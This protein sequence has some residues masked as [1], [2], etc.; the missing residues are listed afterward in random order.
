[1]KLVTAATRGMRYRP[2]VLCTMTCEVQLL[3][4]FNSLVGLEKQSVH[5]RA[6]YSGTLARCFAAVEHDLRIEIVRQGAKLQSRAAAKAA[7]TN[8]VAPAAGN[9]SCFTVYQARD[10]IR[11]L[12]TMSS[13]ACFAFPKKAAYDADALASACP[14]AGDVAKLMEARMVI[15][16]AMAL[17][18][19]AIGSGCAH[20]IDATGYEAS[21]NQL[22]RSCGGLSRQSLVGLVCATNSVLYLQPSS[23]H[24]VLVKEGIREYGAYDVSREMIGRRLEDLGLL[25]ATGARSRGR[26]V[27]RQFGGVRVRYWPVSIVKLIEFL[28]RSQEYHR[29]AQRNVR[30]KFLE[31]L[32]GTTPSQR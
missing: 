21:H 20:I 18:G 24:E 23:L 22:V 26:A 5:P 8:R 15:G 17:I 14:L 7:P 9:A 13:S 27:E 6:F 16:T 25:A 30:S 2:N 31:A 4:V 12:L 28:S 3:Y 11:T 10:S 29:M 1:M 19:N 32:K